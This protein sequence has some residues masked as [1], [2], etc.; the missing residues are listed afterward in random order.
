M[1][2]KDERSWVDWMNKQKT[3]TE[4][5]EGKIDFVSSRITR[6]HFRASPDTAHHVVVIRFRTALNRYRVLRRS[7]GDLSFTPN[8]TDLLHAR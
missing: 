6:W 2:D 8:H 5:S 4:K 3:V 7:F 1:V